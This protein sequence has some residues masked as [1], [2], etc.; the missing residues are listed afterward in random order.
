MEIVKVQPGWPASVDLSDV[1]P[2]TCFI[3]YADFKDENPPVFMQIETGYVDV[4]TGLLYQPEFSSTAV[5]PVDCSLHV[6]FPR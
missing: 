5:I 2:G 3:M 1:P 4:V 6:V